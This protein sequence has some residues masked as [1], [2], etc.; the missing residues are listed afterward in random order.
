M[1]T[2]RSDVLD[3]IPSAVSIDTFCKALEI[4]QAMAY[5]LL[6]QGLVRSIKLGRARR[7][8]T[9]ELARLIEQGV[10]SPRR[11]S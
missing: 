6:R 9:S 8:P 11:V 7:I 2:N 4:S 1:S 5:E 10:P 3:V